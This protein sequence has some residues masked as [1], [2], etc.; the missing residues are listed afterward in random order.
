MQGLSSRL[1]YDSESCAALVNSYLKECDDVIVMSHSDALVNSYLKECDGVIN[2]ARSCQHTQL[3][4]RGTIRIIAPP[5]V[6]SYVPGHQAMPKPAPAPVRHPCHDA[7]PHFCFAPRD[8]WG[9][10]L[11]ANDVIKIYSAH[12]SNNAGGSWLPTPREDH[13]W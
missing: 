1:R 10:L 5:L 13:W 12:V 6:N 11:N 2:V 9:G 7:S 4:S 8:R 3:R